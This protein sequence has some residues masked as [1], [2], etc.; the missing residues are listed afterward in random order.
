MKTNLTQITKRT[1]LLLKTKGRELKRTRLA[2]IH[3]RR[4]RSLTISPQDAILP[5]IAP[6]TTAETHGP[7][8]RIGLALA[9]WS[10]RWFPDPLV[11]ALAGVIVVFLAGTASGESPSAL[12]V[13]AGRSFWSLIPFTMQMVMVIIGGYVVASTPFV[14]GA[15]RRIASLPRTPRA[16][17]ALVALFAMLTSLLSWG[18]SLIFSGLLV[19]EMAQRVRGLDYRAAGGAAYIGLGTVSMLG[20]SSSAAMLMAT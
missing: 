7:L 8:V 5:H 16:A 9:E 1:L 13:Q 4:R 12:A 17:V 2:S 15:I 11:F 19:R 14:R 10:E 3:R 18:L 6:P 20:L